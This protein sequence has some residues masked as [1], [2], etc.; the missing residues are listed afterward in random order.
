MQDAKEGIGDVFADIAGF[1]GFEP[2]LK[3]FDQGTFGIKETLFRLAQID[4]ARQRRMIAFIA[5][6]N[7]EKCSGIARYRF[8]IPGQMRRT[9]I[10]TRRQ[11][12]HNRRV[13]PADPV[14]ADNPGTID[15]GD[16]FVFL[17]ARF[18]DFEN[19][20]M[21]VFDDAGRLAHIENLG[22][23][24]YGTL[25]VHQCRGIMELCIGQ[26]GLQ[27][28]VTSGGEIV[29]IHFNT[30]IARAPAAMFDHLGQVIH[31]VMGGRLHIV[32]GIGDDAV[33][34]HIDRALCPVCIL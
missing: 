15:F 16:Q 34:G 1:G 9:G 20:F 12:R 8:V 23:G 13:I 14:N 19:A 32:I 4:R 27:L 31:R 22:L 26:M 33:M 11:Q 21:H 7:L 24:L 17:H 25:P 6:G 28:G 18:D 3:A 5:T 2:G 10:G 29:V 30:D